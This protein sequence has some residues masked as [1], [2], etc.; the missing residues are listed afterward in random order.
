MNAPLLL[1][2]LAL[3]ADL[4]GP[5]CT[6]PAAG[7]VEACTPTSEAAL[8][9]L[10]VPIF[11][12]IDGPVT[13]EMWHALPPEALPLLE[14][15]A[16]GTGRA[17]ARAR[18]LEGAAALG[19]DGAVHRRLAKDVAAPFAVRAAA[20]RGLGLLVSASRLNAE[21]APFLGSDP[22]LRIR[23][24]AAAALARSALPSSCAAVR[25]QAQR[26]GATGRPAFQRALTTCGDR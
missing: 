6:V 13:S 7:A 4:G 19:S 17:G 21:L 24:T 12:L 26:E 3:G 18:A 15:I 25:T 20:I 10:L 11:G 1:P 5:L 2:A 14:R 8:R 22:D 23:S 16:D 9:E